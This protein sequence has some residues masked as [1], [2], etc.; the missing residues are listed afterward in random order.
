M[1]KCDRCRTETNVTTM[2]MFNTQVIC[3]DCQDAER[4]RPDFEAARQAETEAVLRGDYNFPGVGYSLTG[5]R[6]RGRTR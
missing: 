4:K 1:T 6:S 2:S 3:M 5:R